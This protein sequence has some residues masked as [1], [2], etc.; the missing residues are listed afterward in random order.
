MNQTRRLVW[1]FLDG[2]IPGDSGAASV[3]PWHKTLTGTGTAVKTTNGLEL[4]SSGGAGYTALGMND[5]LVFDIDD[6]IR[7]EFL[8]KLLINTTI[9]A[10]RVF[11][12]LASAR[13][14]T[15]DSIQ[16]Q[17]SFSAALT[18]ALLLE[19]D[20]DASQNVDDIE[21][22]LIWSQNW[23]TLAIDFSRGVQSKSP[24]FLSKGG[25]AD[26]RFYA[27][28]KVGA[29]RPVGLNQAFDLSAYSGGFQPLLQVNNGASGDDLTLCVKEVALELKVQ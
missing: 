20:D 7:I 27:G 14:A 24:P 11:V 25:K 28:N 8:V 1:N 3:G 6:I 5:Q 2:A 17:A 29:E 16:Y 21:T 9:A 10:S 13:N 26:V 22:G 18:N 15:A 12:G 19:I 23:Q 4:R